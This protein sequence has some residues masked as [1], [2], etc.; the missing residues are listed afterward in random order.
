MKTRRNRRTGDRVARF[1]RIYLLV[2]QDAEDLVVYNPIK[3]SN[4]ISTS[5][6]S[7]QTERKM[8]L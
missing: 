4:I 1:Q 7:N 8:Y 3:S 6:L 5:L 2:A